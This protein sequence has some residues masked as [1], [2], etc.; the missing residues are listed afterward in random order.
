VNKVG[1]APLEIRY[2][3][4]GRFPTCDAASI[5]LSQSPKPQSHAAFA[6][7]ARVH[8][9]AHSIEVA[10]GNAHDLLHELGRLRREQVGYQ[11]LRRR[12]L[13]RDRRERGARGKKGPAGDRFDHD[14][15]PQRD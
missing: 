1:R 12:R 2:S 11:R 4:I 3:A 9:L 10:V 13:K 8:E 7:G 15:A 6:S 5:A 14:G